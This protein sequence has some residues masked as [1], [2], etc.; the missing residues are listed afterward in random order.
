ML[1][2]GILT[3]N[4]P[5][6]LEHTLAT[7]ASSGLLEYTD[8]VFAVIQHSPRQPEEEAVCT[9]YNIR[10]V[11][12]PDNGR[13]GSGFK[14]IYEHAKHEYILFLE[15]DFANYASRDATRDYLDTALDL[16]VNHGVDSVR[17]RSR[18]NPGDPNYSMQYYRDIF[19]HLDRTEMIS[20]YYFYLS[21]SMYWLDPVREYPEYF[22][23]VKPGYMFASSQHCQY[24]NNPYVCSKAF[25]KRAILPY[26]TPG[27]DIE[28]AGIVDGWFHGAYRCVFGGGIFTH[29]RI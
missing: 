8:D 14:A 5:D 3:Y 6:T 18:T 2:I 19:Q 28:T 24:T 13:M 16:L 11:S 27:S 21:E 7:Y 12:M 1:S 25:F 9:R 10:H 26:A 29:K 17:G 15:N 22:T 20:R 4:A 23:E